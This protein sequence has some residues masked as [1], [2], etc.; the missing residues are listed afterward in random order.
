[1]NDVFI[2]GTQYHRPPNPARDQHEFHLTRIKN[3]LGFNT[4][5][6]F[7]EWSYMHTGP[8]E[9]DF[10][11]QQEIFDICE[12]LGLKVFI[13]T[14]LESS[15]YW[16]EKK[17]PEARYVSANGHAVEL[18]PNGNTQCGGYPGLCFHNDAIKQE[19][20][21]FLRALA[22]AFKDRKCLIGYDCWNEPHLEPAWIDNT[23]IDMGDRVFCY[24]EATKS[25]FRQWLKQKY[26]D[27]ENL[28]KAWTRRYREWD[29][30]APPSRQGHYAD[31]LDWSRFWFDELHEHM[32]FRY[33]IL[34]EI[35]P[36]L[37]V[38]SHSGAVPPFL[39]RANA[40]I[41]NWAFAEP[42][43]MWGTSMAPRYQNWGLAESAGILELTRS[44]CKGKKF[45][46]SE[47]TGGSANLNG[48]KKTPFTRPKDI[49]TWNWLGAVYGAKGII[50][51]C[52]LTE[53]TGFEAGSYGLVEYNGRITKRAQEAARQAKL[54]KERYH[55]FKEFLLKTEIAILYDPANSAMLFAMDSNSELYAKSHIGYYK[56]IWNNDLYARYVTYDTLDGID[57]KILIV[58]MCLTIDEK[59]AEK[60]KSFVEQGG[61]LIAEARM[62]L[63]DENGFLQPDLPSFGLS[64]VSGLV[65]EEA[66]YSDVSNKPSVNNSKDSD[67][68][69]E[70][71][72][73]PMVQ[74]SGGSKARFHVQEYLAPLLTEDAE[75]IG[76]WNDICLAAHN[77][78]GKGEVYYFGT[79]L[80]LALFNES[81][82]AHTIISDILRKHV[83]PQV[84]GK[85]LRPRLIENGSE[86]ILTVFNDSRSEGI[87]D[88][89]T[90]PEK[91][92][93]AKD[94]FSGKVLSIRKN[95]IEIIVEPEDVAVIHLEKE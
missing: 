20:E 64:E 67:W 5:K 47:L 45:W 65:E 17:H 58:P 31:W 61:I 9:F 70:I 26:D 43:D 25:R 86:G 56:N 11:E 23:W 34:K 80:G 90:L 85:K 15:P 68:P 77:E 41:D 22:T 78:Y 74:M 88:C 57:E 38:M 35:S 75:C 33:N 8:G 87:S 12:K 93:T 49:R 28:N 42:V 62:G 73:G 50:Y 69:E 91:F 48:F 63:F 51:W 14:R 7:F 18:G 27:V 84:S 83:K 39:S 94:L 24:C 30:A 59:T 2:Y 95:A 19:A 40:F 46:I 44:A 10:E 92:N 79:Y 82:G 60:I 1:M 36:N 3:E 13:Q 32:H 72:R 4:V 21:N 89:I 16:L 6:L 55:I 66:V 53:S 29:E 76:K 52:Y 81:E 37:F 71:L 54:F